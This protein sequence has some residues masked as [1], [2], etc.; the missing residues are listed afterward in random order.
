[1]CEHST[2]LTELVIPDDGSARA[3][4]NE[5]HFFP[6]EAV[7]ILAMQLRRVLGCSI[8]I[9]ECESAAVDFVQAMQKCG[10]KVFRPG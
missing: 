6:E 7:Q 8:P 3:S 4:R 2:I 9:S 5:E 10:W 1:M